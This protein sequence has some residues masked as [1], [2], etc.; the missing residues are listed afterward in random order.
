[1]QLHNKILFIGPMGAG[2]TTAIQ[3]LSDQAAATTEVQNS[4]RALYD[5]QTTTVA[6]DYGSI[7]LDDNQQIHLYGIPGQ[8]H[9]E[10][11]WP[12]I[13]KGAIGAI[14][15]VNASHP[16][17]QNDTLYLLQAFRAQVASGSV[18]VAANRTDDAQ[19]QQ[20]QQILTSHQY[21][22]PVLLTD[23]RQRDDLVLAL[24]ILIAN[25]EVE[26]CIHD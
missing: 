16:D 5:K 8:K 2:K 22:L 4:N 20:L 1:M 19:L 24:E 15:L 25:L 7:Q 12:V 10:P 14:L 21:Y 9:F 17:W 26:T 11:V 3:T 6:M 18:V 13:A 23:P